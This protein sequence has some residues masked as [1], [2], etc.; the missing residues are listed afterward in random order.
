MLCIRLL[1]SDASMPST[2]KLS[3]RLPLA[4]A[5]AAWKRTSAAL[6][7]ASSPAAARIASSADWRASE[8]GAGRIARRELRGVDLDREADLEQLEQAARVAPHRGGEEVVEGPAL[9]C[10]TTG[11]RP[12]ATSMRPRACSER[13]PSRTVSRLT[14][15]LRRQLRLGRQGV[16]RLDVAAEDDPLEPG[17]DAVDGG[18]G[19]TGRGLAR[20]VTARAP[21]RCQS[22]AH[23]VRRPEQIKAAPACLVC[24]VPRPPLRTESLCGP[25]IRRSERSARS[26]APL[27]PKR[28]VAKLI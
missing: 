7:A 3:I 1:C 12:C 24:A 26:S 9:G 6:N 27:A 4:A 23:G 2:R 15:R 10:A 18:T 22:W 21:S 20:S 17:D 19:A 25:L 8:V 28:E 11:R 16:P 13:T 14:P 5:M